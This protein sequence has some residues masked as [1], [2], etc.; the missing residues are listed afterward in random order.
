MDALSKLIKVCQQFMNNDFSIEEFQYK[1]ETI[2]L[3]EKCKKTLEK[4]QYNACN[5]LEEII[6]CY[7]DSQKKYADKVATSLIQ[8]VRK[9][10]KH[11]KAE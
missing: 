2:N 11:F 8:A 6:Y 4:A 3:P 9:E 10:R 7:S 5:Q 1:I